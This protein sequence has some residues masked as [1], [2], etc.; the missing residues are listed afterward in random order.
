MDSA[1]YAEI[2]PNGYLYIRRKG[3]DDP[4]PLICLSPELIDVVRAFLELS[5][6]STSDGPELSRADYLRT[7]G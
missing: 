5:S 2:E 7:L 4:I 6:N 3:S 1:Y